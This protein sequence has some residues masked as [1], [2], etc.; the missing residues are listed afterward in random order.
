VTHGLRP[1]AGSGSA[2]RRAAW[3]LAVGL[4][5]AVVYMATA[6]FSGHLSPL[7][8]LPL[9]D[10]LIPPAPYRWVDPPADL[11][12]T[13]VEPVSETSEVELGNRGS[14]TAIL[15]TDDAQVTVVLPRGAFP[16]ARR[17]RG[18]RVRIEPLAADEV[19]PPD[20]PQ[21]ILGNAYRLRANY[22]PSGE[23]APLEIDARVV[24]VYP[25]FPT[26]HG[27]HAVIASADGETWSA[28]ETN[29]FRSIQQADG[30]IETL[31]YVAVAQT[32]TTPTPTPGAE[33]GAD[34]A[35]IAI[36]V[37]LVALAAGAAFALRPSGRNG[38]GGT[39]RSSKGS[40]SGRRKKGSSRPAKGAARG[41]RPGS[42]RSR[43]RRTRRD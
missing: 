18:V 25:F 3:A 13:N 35:T 42:N 11:A 33:N 12:P 43:S 41:S 8:R 30:P 22:V 40:G 23:P 9:L 7:A 32:G 26:D 10:G 16:E 1:V 39:R 6:W 19:E 27:E 2:K 14:V 38:R 5:V 29:D 31:G 36:V 21:R 37:G 24:L 28:V 34:V 20:P 17:Q 4:G 15:S